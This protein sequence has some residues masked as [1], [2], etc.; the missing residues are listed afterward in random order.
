MFITQEYVYYRLCVL[1]RLCENLRFWIGDRTH[2]IKRK[3]ED[4]SS[5][6]FV[7]FVIWG[8]REGVGKR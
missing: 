3:G 6:Q 2:I 8:K 1:V 4:R 5:E 7:I